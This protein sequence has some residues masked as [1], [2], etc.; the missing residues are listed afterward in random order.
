LSIQDKV[1]A[2]L[3]FAI[4]LPTIKGS[5]TT[6]FRYSAKLENT[7]DEDLMVNLAADTPIGFLT[8]FKLSGQ[9]VTSFTLG[10]NPTKTISIELDPIVEIPE[11]NH[12]FMIYVTGDALQ[13]SLDLVAEVTGP[14][15]LSLTGL[16]RR[17]SGKA[18]AGKETTLQLLVRNTGTASAHGVEMSST[19]P[20]GWTISFDPEVI[21]EAP[22]GGQ[23]EVT[24]HLV[25]A[26][27]AVAGDYMVTMRAKPVDGTKIGSS[28]QL[29]ILHVSSN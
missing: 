20:S 4:D 19:A 27:K 18:N 12:L 7:G 17:L 16:D 29:L 1:P 10:A 8:K 2:S 15:I 25:P 14:Q 21:T 11:G 26:E 23:V 24:A 6:T 28:H 22:A 3:S 9:E 13:A 5:P